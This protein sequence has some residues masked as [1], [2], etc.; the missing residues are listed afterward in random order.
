M[1]ASSWKANEHKKTWGTSL[2]S[3]A[4]ELGA[5]QAQFCLLALSWP[6]PLLILGI[7]DSVF[8]AGHNLPRR[9]MAFS[10]LCSL[11]RSGLADGVKSQEQ[12]LVES[13]GKNLPFIQKLVSKK[14]SQTGQIFWFTES[15]AMLELFQ[16]FTQANTSYAKL[17]GL[18][19]ITYWHTA[20]FF[21]F[22]FVFFG[23]KNL[24]PSLN[25][26]FLMYRS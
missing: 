20:L 16:K 6:C 15:A 8:P 11:W 21:G 3:R 2:L 22:F 9:S 5:F 14:R 26:S 13:V 1:K 4:V 19:I 7:T 12:F 10:L 25:I 24:V 17:L 23:L 18:S